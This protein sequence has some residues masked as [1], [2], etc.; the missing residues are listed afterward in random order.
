MSQ[1]DQTTAKGYAS[2]ESD[3][4]QASSSSSRKR[5]SRAGQRSVTT[6]SAAQ[7]ERKRANDREAQRAIRQRT[8]GHIDGL[9]Q[10]IADLALAKDSQE[11]L[12]VATQHRNQEL[13]QENAYFRTR[14]GGDAFVL[15]VV[16]NEGEQ[17]IAI[18]PQR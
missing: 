8:K 9:E 4:K 12:L 14:F 5:A 15:N 7:L 2:S 1:T 3:S 6:L 17:L 10:R 16:E 11:K 13:E 18:L